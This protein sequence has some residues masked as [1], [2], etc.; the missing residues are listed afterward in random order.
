MFF[1][2]GKISLISN[3][4]KRPPTNPTYIFK[5]STIHFPRVLGL[6]IRT[7]QVVDVKGQWLIKLLLLIALHDYPHSMKLP[8]LFVITWWSLH[9]IVTSPSTYNFSLFT[10]H[11]S[12]VF[13]LSPLF[14]THKVWVVTFP[15][16]L[17][18]LGVVAKVRS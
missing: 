16:F 15:Y 10:L 3:M 1:F 18:E 4:E 11:Q 2:I 6:W 12:Y 8:Y 13:M 7:S 14:Y 17:K 9:L 5:K